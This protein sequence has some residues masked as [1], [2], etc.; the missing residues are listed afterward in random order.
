[1]MMMIDVV[2]LYEI[3]LLTYNRIRVTRF[4]HPGTQFQQPSTRF[5]NRVISQLTFSFLIRFDTVPSRSLVETI[6]VK[7][8]FNVFYKSLK[9]CFLRFFKFFNVFI[10]M[11]FLLV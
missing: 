6:D 7:N 4:Q 5:L 8:V 1:M 11:A 2:A 10:V 9:T 3:F